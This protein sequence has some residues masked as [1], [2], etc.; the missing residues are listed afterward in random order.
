MSGGLGQ[1]GNLDLLTSKFFVLSSIPQS[2]N[3]LVN[4]FVKRSDIPKFTVFQSDL[5]TP[6]LFAW[7]AC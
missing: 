5:S 1:R 4:Q 3:S 7:G 2:S 6:A